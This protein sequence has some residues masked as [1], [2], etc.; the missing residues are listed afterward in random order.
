MRTRPSAGCRKAACN[1]SHR[2]A[3][4]IFSRLKEQYARKSSTASCKPASR[5]RLPRTRQ[6]QRAGP[7]ARAQDTFQVNTCARTQL[8]G[9]ATHDDKSRARVEDVV[10]PVRDGLLTIDERGTCATMLDV[11][12][13][14][15]VHVGCLDS[16]A[17]ICQ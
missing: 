14:S 2:S 15:V 5:G 11:S 3:C 12:Q 17:P 16:L 7:E 13:G 10:D 8:G 9:T 6:R 4:R 1:G